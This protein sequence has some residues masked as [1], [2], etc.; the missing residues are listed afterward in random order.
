MQ[1]DDRGTTRTVAARYALPILLVVAVV[2][3]GVAYRQEISISG[4]L[5]MFVV[6]ALAAFA[7]YGGN[8]AMFP[9]GRNTGDPD[10]V[11]Y[12]VAFD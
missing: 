8:R 1:D 10:S 3:L 12:V 7:L 5:R 6:L 2:I 11:R 4:H 9:P